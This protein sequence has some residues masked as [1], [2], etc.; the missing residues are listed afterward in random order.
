[1]KRSRR[2]TEKPNDAFVE[3]APTCMSNSL[4]P[5]LVEPEGISGP[6]KIVLPFDR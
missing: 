4:L 2:Y 1:M 5:L 6:K 3:P